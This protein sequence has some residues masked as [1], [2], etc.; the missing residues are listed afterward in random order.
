[1]S[2]KAFALH[3]GFCTLHCGSTRKIN[4]SIFLY[5]SVR[6]F[7]VV[8]GWVSSIRWLAVWAM[9]MMIFFCCIVD[10]RKTSRFISSQDYCQR[11]S[12]CPISDTPP[13]SFEPALNLSS[14]YVERCCTVV[15]TTTP[16]RLVECFNI[17]H[18]TWNFWLF[19]YIPAFWYFHQ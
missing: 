5:I 13:L 8:V 1:M 14:G 3:L 9:M 16:R 2:Q 18:F 17:F 10:R 12:S 11:S 7:Y 6:S 19:N 4:V 15:I